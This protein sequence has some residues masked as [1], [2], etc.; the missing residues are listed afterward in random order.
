M[1]QRGGLAQIADNPY[2]RLGEETDERGSHD[3]AFLQSQLRSDEHIHDGDWPA[4]KSR[5]RTRGAT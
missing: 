1:V 4:T 2:L 5:T 3:D